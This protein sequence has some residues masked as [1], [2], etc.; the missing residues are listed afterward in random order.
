[1]IYDEQQEFMLALENLLFWQVI[2]NENKQK[3]KVAES[4]R[5]PVFEEFSST[6][7]FPVR[8]GTDPG[9]VRFPNSPNS[10]YTR[11]SGNL[12]NPGQASASN[13]FV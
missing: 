7:I 5:N 2:L 8:V 9:L 12:T 3:T 13:N 6:F 4:F 10:I 11:G 1:M